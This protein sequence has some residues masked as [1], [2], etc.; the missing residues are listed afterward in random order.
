MARYDIVIVG[1]AIVGSSIAY[2]L[3][4]EGFAGTIALVERDPQFER[5]ATTLSCASIRQQFSIAENIRLSQF[6]LALFRRLEEEFGPGS[7]IGF[8]ENGYLIL[9]SEEGLPVLSANHAVQ[10]AEGAEIILE[11]AA[12]LERRFP[13]LST[14]GIVAGAYG[15]A[16]EGWFDAHAMLSLFRKALRAK[17]VDMMTQTVTGI[18]RTGNRA[19]AVTLANGETLEAGIVVNAAGPNAGK[20]AA[21]AGMALPVE[22]RKRS[23]FVFEARDKFADLPLL[24]DPTGV[25]VRPEGS[26]YIAGGAENEDGETAADTAD[27]EP[28]WSLF[29]DAIWPALATRI[30]AFEAI[31]ATRAWAGH[32]DYNTLDQNAVIG[33]HPEVGN[34]I[35]ANGFSG[36]GLQQ[37]PAVGKSVAELIVHGAYRTV[38]CSV[39]GYERIAAGRPFRELNV[40]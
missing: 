37:A 6:T 25:Y 35:F 33:P 21:M 27:F 7:D 22:P 3:R 40:I 9:A 1:G 32:Y 14:E 17:S 13:Y 29:E 31:K 16:G 38:D 26:V 23:V 2:Y 39:F 5:A 19:T 11:D 10:K 12:A 18:E 34:F 30:P 15:S 20:V 8:R 4:Q 24:V 28:D 36:H